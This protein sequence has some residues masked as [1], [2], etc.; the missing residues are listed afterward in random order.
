MKPTLTALAI[1]LTLAAAPAAAFNVDMSSLFPTLTYPEPAPQ[2]VTQGP[3]G[4]DR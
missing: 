3:A 1:G 4:M 2:P